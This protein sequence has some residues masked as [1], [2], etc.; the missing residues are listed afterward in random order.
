MKK[1]KAE[2]HLSSGSVIVK[3][4]DDEQGLLDVVNNFME[5]RNKSGSVETFFYEKEKWMLRGWTK[6]GSIN[7]MPR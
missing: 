2:I 6:Y 1:W 4:S 7:Q 5:F 3:E